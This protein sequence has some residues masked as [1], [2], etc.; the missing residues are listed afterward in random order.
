MA[1]NGIGSSPSVAFTLSVYAPLVVS[2][3]P[4][5]IAQGGTVPGSGFQLATIN[6]TEVGGTVKLKA[7]GLPKGLALSDTGLLTGTVSTKDAAQAYSVTITASSKDG[8]TAVTGT[9]TATITVTP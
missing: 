5:S 2:T 1:S 4:F 7:T 3:A 6:G 8:K 9:G